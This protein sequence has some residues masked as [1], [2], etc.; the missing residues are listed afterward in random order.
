MSRNNDLD[1]IGTR[2]YEG[3]RHRTYS[4]VNESVGYGATD[5]DLFEAPANYGDRSFP[6]G[7]WPGGETT[8]PA[9]DG[10]LDR[11]GARIYRR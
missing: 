5:G 4:V 6:T 8:T 11:L 9:P 7:P 3:N 10:E 1:R 2:M